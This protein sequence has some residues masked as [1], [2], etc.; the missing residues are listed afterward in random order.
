[1][2]PNCCASPRL[3]RTARQAV[4]IPGGFRRARRSK[5]H[6]NSPCLIRTPVPFAAGVSPLYET[7]SKVLTLS[8]TAP[9]TSSG[10]KPFCYQMPPGGRTWS[11]R[12]CGRVAIRVQNQDCCKAISGRNRGVLRD[13]GK[14]VPISRH[15][16][17]TSPGFLRQEYWGGTFLVTTKPAQT[18][19]FSPTVT[20]R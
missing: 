18:T 6:A 7:D 12:W 2:V 1:M 17:M 5:F 8:S 10:M 9:A 11:Y 13:A 15:E 4:S 19:E 14:V 20:R 3:S 16:R